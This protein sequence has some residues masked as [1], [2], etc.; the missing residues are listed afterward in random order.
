MPILDS[1]FSIKQIINTNSRDVSPKA[2]LFGCL[3][4]TV[5]GEVEEEK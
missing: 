1:D 4:V 2:K 5:V 3:A